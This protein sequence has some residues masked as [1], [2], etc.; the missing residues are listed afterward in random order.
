MRTRWQ[1]HGELTL[2]MFIVG[3]SVVVGKVLVARFPVFW[4]AGMRFLIA[5]A[6]L[7]P[8]VLVR[9]R[10]LPALPHKDWLW[11]ILQAF[12]GVFLFSVLLLYGLRHTTAAESG[13]ITSTSPAILGLLSALLLRERPTWHRTAG[14]ALS[15]CGVL[16]VNLMAAGE[17]RANGALLGNLLVLGA[18]A[19]EALFTIF[20]KLMSPR[21]TPVTGTALISALGLLMFLPLALHEARS[22]DLAGITALEWA[23]LGY[24]GVVVTVVAFIAW[25]RGVAKVPAGTAAVFTGVWPVSA[26]LLSYGLL[27]EPFALAHLAGLAC[28]LAGIGLIARD[29]AATA[30]PAGASLPRR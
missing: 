20:R 21:V 7:V 30:R 17:G 8:V 29:D 24:Q 2:A 3:S 16:A 5:S 15:F 9:E 12:T 23:A 26:V 18:V 28:V 25:F 6:V 1:A 19:G 4:V 14:I 10:G 11:L 22:V 13:I 27:H